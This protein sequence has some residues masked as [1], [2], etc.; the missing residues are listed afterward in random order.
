MS[1]LHES[2]Q[3]S[4]IA[5]TVTEN[6]WLRIGLAKEA[7]FIEEIVT[8][9]HRRLGVLI[10]SPQPL[11]IGIG[12]DIEYV[13][14]WL[15]DGSS[16]TADIL[17]ILGMGGIGK[18]TLAKCVYRLNCGEFQKM[19]FIEGISSLDQL[20][21]LL[22]KKGFHPGCKVIITTQDASLTEKYFLDLEVQPK[23]TKCFLEGLYP[24]E[25]LNLLSL[26]AFKCNNPKEGYEEVSEKLVEYCGGH[27]W[28]VKF[29]ERLYVIKIES[30][31]TILKACELHTVLGIMNLVDRSL[32]SIDSDN[33][34]MMHQ[35]V[36]ETGRDMVR[37]ESPDMP[38]KRSRLWCHEESL[39]VFETKKGEGHGTE[40]VQ[41]LVLDMRT[42]EKDKLYELETDAL[43]KMDHLMLL[44]LN[45]VHQLL[46][47]YK[48]FPQDLR[49]LCMHGFPLEYIPRDLQLENL[50][51]L[52]MSYSRLVSFDLSYSDPQRI[53]NTQKLTGLGSIWEQ[54][55]SLCGLLE[56]PIPE[57]R[58]KLIESDSKDKPLLRS[59]KILNLSYSEQLRSLGGF[60]EFPTLERLILSNCV[61]LIEVC[62]SIK[63]CDGL[64][65]IDLS[66]CNEAGKF[67]RTI[68]K[69]KNVKILN[70][71]GC[72]LS[73]FP[74][75]MSDLELVEMGKANNIVMNPQA[76]SSAVVEVIPRDFR[77]FR[78]CLPSSLVCMSLKDN[79]LSNESFPMD[80][81]SLF[82]LKELYLDGND[83]VSMP[84]CVRTLP[85]IEKLS[86]GNCD[87]LETIEH[88][89]RTLKHLIFA[90]Y[91]PL[92]KVV[93]DPD[94]SPIK[95]SGTRSEGPFIEGMFKEA[96]MADVQE[97]LLHSLGWSD[98][99]FTNIH[100]VG[101]TSGI[102]MVYEFGIFSTMFEG[103]EMPNW[104][105]E[106]S[107]GSS[108]SFTIPS[109]PNNLRGLN[110]WVMLKVSA[111]ITTFSSNI[112]IR[113]ITKNRTWIYTYLE[114]FRYTMRGKLV[115]LSH[116]MFS[117]NEMEDG[118]Q[119]T[120]SIDNPWARECGME[121]MYD[122]GRNKMEEE[123]DVLGYYKSWN[124]IIGDDLSPFR[125]A[126]P[127]EEYQLN[128][129]HFLGYGSGSKYVG[130]Y[131][132][133]KYTY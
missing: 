24:Y 81:S 4:V 3:S 49:W 91:W 6:V 90:I 102:K 73:E 129:C 63:Q 98:L 69:V 9:I 56:L 16:H 41:G 26:S 130:T 19:S 122:D 42:L 33:K 99:D 21:A 1:T 114:F 78:I 61:S 100:P 120:I 10:S 76:S 18:T 29:W 11:L 43:T 25:S 95:L 59:L 27:H 5:F 58:Q 101:G 116:W 30:T 45:F 70:L 51:I 92:G 119:I 48:N 68:E 131:V 32:L 36:Q 13:T 107:E 50:V 128:R 118:D 28:L 103:R 31:E 85:R 54:V 125:K 132:V 80:M 34:L 62:D 123:E 88:P 77:S 64:Y 44:Q 12:Y 83:I 86:I 94:M 39:K 7:D 57:N 2:R 37:Q 20:V 105:S 38:E 133:Y 111:V 72:N 35:L 74:T 109:S 82:M 110:F 106:R 126:T 17:T 46:G 127:E 67:L 15:K 8:N 52:D 79:H 53:E 93:F 96:N 60:S 71:D 89:P 22:G 55:C 65:L 97:E 104:I 23:H 66:Y 108:V 112:K 40:N 87:R 115:H 121:L 113:N 14:T 75:E 124:Y 47:S 117:K 84:K